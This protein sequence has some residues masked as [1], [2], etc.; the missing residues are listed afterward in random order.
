MAAD[1]IGP[2][3]VS[4]PSRTETP[5]KGPARAL[6]LL[7][8]GTTALLVLSTVAFGSWT[9]VYQVALV[10]GLGATPALVAAGLLTAAVG[11]AVLPA[12]GRGLSHDVVTRPG[13]G[14][15][16]V[17]AATATV[18]VSLGVTGRRGLMVAVVVAAA[19]AWVVTRKLGRRGRG[20]AAD[21]LA[22]G[23]GTVTV[24][25]SPG[26]T[27]LWPVAWFWAVA[28]AVLASVTARPDGDDAY[29]VNLSEWVADRGTFPTR[30]T[31]LAD[32]AFPALRSHSPPVHS[33]EGLFGAVAHVLDLRGGVVTYLVAAPALTALA[34][35]ALA[36]LVSLSRVRLAPLALSAAVVFLL[37]SGG[38][39]ASFGN[40]FALRMWQGKAA[41][42]TLVIPLVTAAAIAYIGRGGWR[43][44]AVLA[45]AVVGTVGASNTA[46]FLVPVLLAGLVVAAWVR[47][48]PR[49]ALGV[50]ATLAYPLLCGAVVLLL[51]PDV[52]ES[53]GAGAETA[54]LPLN[55]LLAVPGKHGLFVVTIVAVTLG[56]AGL[57]SRA[58]RAVAVCVTLAAGVALLPP[59]TDVLVS[60]A[61]VGSVIW[62]MW[63]T[64][65]VPLLVAGVVGV[66]ADVVRRPSVF[67]RGLGRLAP[68]VPVTVALAV[69]LLPLVGGSWIWSS[70]NGARWVSPM[71]WKAPVGAEV[72]ARGA[73]RV[74]K[75]GDVV[76]LPWDASRV[77][78]GM[79]V[80]VHPVSARAIYLPAYAGIPGAKVDERTELQRFVDSRTPPVHTL[81]P[82]VEDLSVDTACVSERR[83]KAVGALEVLGFTV[84]SKPGDLVCLRRPAG[85]LAGSSGG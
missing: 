15:L 19:A 21:R 65:P 62:R 2:A 8:Q 48:G 57:R 81:R 64:V 51:A 83:G 55:P 30:D 52:P 10:T 27:G 46:V 17:A 31:M 69:A 16:A 70:A 3:R 4:D 79:S 12:F 7:E 34:V 75:D 67:A 59:V 14:A 25:S 42:A 85:S 43:R 38:A 54:T 80:D 32:Q 5:L 26:Q 45:L 68:A 50:A 77:L 84:V 49:R 61:G 82:L 53:A 63:W 11:Y 39:G 76:L 20:V 13:W 66:A 74:S 44:L 56:W 6:A 23:V 36:W 58:A 29:F 18:A 24:R 33:I 41:L 72:E 1:T 78:A 71:S 28:C 37:A 40:F 9:L 47:G 22:G 35:L 73:L 60:A